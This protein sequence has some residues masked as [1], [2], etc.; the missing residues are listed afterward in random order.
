MSARA[1]TKSAAII[2][3]TLL[4]LGAQLSQADAIADAERLLRVSETERHFQFAARK[5]TS[6]LLRVYSGIVAMSANVE[7]PRH[8]TQE[9]ESCYMQAYAWDRFAGGIAEILAQHFTSKELQLLTDF[10]RNRGLSPQDIESFKQAITKARGIEEQT[11]LFMFNSSNGCVEQASRVITGYVDS[12]S[13]TAD[14]VADD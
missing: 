8:I 12:L 6:D 1:K 2:L 5:Q 7:L 3:S 10:Y 11:A 13:S 14:D 9:I 4:G